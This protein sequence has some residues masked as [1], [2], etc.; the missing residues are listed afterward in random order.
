[1]ILPRR[2]F[3][4]ALLALASPALSARPLWARGGGDDRDDDD[5]DDDDD[6]DDA[7]GGSGQGRGRGGD[8]AAPRPDK[9][10]DRLPALPPGLRRIG[11]DGSIETL[12]QGLYQRRDRRGRLIESR[13]A[14]SGDRTRLRGP[15]FSQ[16]IEIGRMVTITD[17]AGWREEFATDHYRLFDPR[18]NLVTRRPLTR[19]DT[20]RL[21]DMLP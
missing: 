18:G 12:G 4:I 15:G 2:P 8:H 3:V 13:Q 11:A 17:R 9:T 20:A 1:M 10:R 6:D 7:G 21:R 5:H 19:A 16:I 14:R